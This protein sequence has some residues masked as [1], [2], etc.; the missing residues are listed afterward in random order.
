MCDRKGILSRDRTDLNAKKQAFAIEES[1]DLADAMK[2]ADVFLGVSA[3]GVVSVEMVK[4]MA[5]DPIVL[6]LV[7]VRNGFNQLN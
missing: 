6:V 7:D 2:N 3:P 4:S 1:G 5:A